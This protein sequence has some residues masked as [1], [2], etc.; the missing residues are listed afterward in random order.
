MLLLPALLA[1]VRMALY[2][3]PI[4]EL[5]AELDAGRGVTTRA[6]S[7]FG[8]GRLRQPLLSGQLATGSGGIIGSAWHVYLRNRGPEGPLSRSG[9]I[10]YEPMHELG[11]H[12]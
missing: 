8:A 2:V 1:L 7:A 9:Q 3:L 5:D 12:L 4:R 11:E 10:S 6:P